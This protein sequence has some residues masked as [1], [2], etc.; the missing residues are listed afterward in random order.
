MKYYNPTKTYVEKECVSNH[1]DEIASYGKKAIILTGS[2]SSKVN[3]SL[4]DICFALNT[5]SISYIIFD[6]VESD[7]S[8]KT[9]CDAAKLAIDGDADFCIGVG[10]GSPMDAAKAVSVLMKNPNEVENPEHIFFVERNADHSPIIEIPTTC[11]TG[12]EVTPYSVLTDRQ[13]GGKRTIFTQLF[14]SLSLVD[15][16]YLDTAT[17]Y[18]CIYPYV[19]TLAHLVESYLTTRANDYNRFYSTIGLKN[20]GKSTKLMSNEEDF[21][22]ISKENKERLMQTAMY[23][24]MSIAMNGTTLPHGLGA[25][26]SNEMHIPHGESVAIFIPGFLRNYDGKL[27][28]EAILRELGFKDIDQLEEYL[29]SVIGKISIEEESW[30]HIVD[31]MMSNS[32]KLSSYPYQMTREKL[33][34]YLGEI[35]CK[36]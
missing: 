31:Q 8:I 34:S 3:G 30:N 10:G 16:K 2:H 24:G 9:I 33:D 17:Y 23:G 35:I 28:V 1:T 21:A 22:Q 14:P 15:A 11:G 26:L 36:E 32:H 12:S 20:W 6:S 7:P 13:N 5:R 29:I 4:D 18:D 19:D 25:S 27:E